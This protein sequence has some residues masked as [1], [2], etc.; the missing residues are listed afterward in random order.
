MAQ[1][2]SS[3]YKDDA[4]EGFEQTATPL[5][6]RYCRMD[7]DYPVEICTEVSPGVIVGL[8]L[9]LLDA[10]KLYTHLDRVLNAIINEGE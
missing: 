10:I 1:P 3:F 2:V 7:T 4:L 5:E 6:L 8:D 9:T